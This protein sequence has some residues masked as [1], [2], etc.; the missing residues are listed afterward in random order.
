MKPNLAKLPNYASS[1]LEGSSRIFLGYGAQPSGCSQYLSQAGLRGV[2]KA[3]LWTEGSVAFLKGRFDGRFGKARGA[4]DHV[5]VITGRR[6]GSY[7]C[8]TGMVA[9]VE[10]THLSSWGRKRA[11]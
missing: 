11:C 7:F 2:R 9:N 1:N 10:I 8:A 5:L 6:F 4:R 3:V